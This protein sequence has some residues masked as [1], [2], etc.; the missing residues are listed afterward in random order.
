[1][2]R[3]PPI[4]AGIPTRHS[5]PP[6]LRAAASRISAE[7]DTP[8]P[9]IASSPWNSARPRHPSR[10]RTTRRTPRSLTR[11]LL[12]PPI[13]ET[14]S[15]SR[16]A[17]MSAWRMS[18]TSCGTTKMS[19]VPPMRS[20]VWKL[21]GSLNRSTPRTTPSMRPSQSTSRV[22]ALQQLRAEL[23][24]VAG[25]ERD[26]E[27]AATD[28][29]R[30]V[31]DDARAVAAEVSDIAMSVRPDPVGEIPARAT[32]ARP[33]AGGIDGHRV[34]LGSQAERREQLL[35]Q[36]HG[37]CVAVRLKHRHDPTV[38]PGL[39]G[40]QGRSEDRKSVM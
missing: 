7:S 39:G 33:L 13:T 36:V 24:H 4:V 35:S 38:E 25:A 31:L 27:I 3:A 26:H 11:G 5:M 2:A 17:N 22:Q 37:A 1:M 12:P 9:A 8:A 14:G 29:L 23:A 20:E 32:G 18:S 19:A 30:E 15:C 16:S 21:R 10:R 6:R 34:R 28:D 40:S